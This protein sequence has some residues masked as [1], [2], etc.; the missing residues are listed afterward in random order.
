MSNAELVARGEGAFTISGV[1]D[2]STVEGLLSRSL[3]LFDGA[4]PVLLDL[5]GVTRANSGGLA[6]LL[7]W[8]D[9]ARRRGREL[10]ITHLPTAL[11]DIARISNCMPLLTCC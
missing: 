4:G 9:Q 8:T 1:L 10:H 5:S 11:V 6:L 3:A 7:E 2:F